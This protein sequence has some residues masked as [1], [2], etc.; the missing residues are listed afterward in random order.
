M[1][2]IFADAEFTSGKQVENPDAR[3]SAKPLEQGIQMI[4]A[5]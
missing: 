1:S 3:R 4:D 5:W 2:T